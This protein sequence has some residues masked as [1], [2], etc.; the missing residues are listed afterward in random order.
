M[1]KLINRFLGVVVA[2][3][4]LMGSVMPN[5][6]VMADTNH[7]HHARDTVLSAPANGY[8]ITLTQ[9]SGYIPP[10]D[11]KF[12]AYQIFTGTVEKKIGDSAIDNPGTESTAIPLT[13]IKWGNA[14]GDVGTSTWQD[15]IVEFVLAL[16]SPPSGTEDNASAF[17]GFTQFNS[18]K[19]VDGSRL[20]DRFYKDLPKVNNSDVDFDKLATEVA[21]VISEHNDREWLQAFNDILG[22]YGENYGST[23]A[24]KY[25]IQCYDNDAKDGA[26]AGNEYKIIV[27]AGYYMVLDRSEVDNVGE[28][29][30]ARML[31]VADNIKQVIKEDAPTLDKKIIREDDKPYGTDVAGV[32]DTVKFQLNSKLPSNYDYYTLGYQYKFEDTFSKGLTLQLKDASVKDVYVTVTVKGVLNDDDTWNSGTYTISKESIKKDGA[33]THDVLYA[34]KETYEANKLTVEF[35]CLKEILITDG[36]KEYTLGC[37]PDDTN[38]RSEIYVTYNAMINQNA[39]VSSSTGATA[40]NGN[41]NTATLE[42]SDNPQSYEDTDTTAPHEAVVYIF[43][44]DITKV[45]AADFLKNDGNT[46]KSA[47]EGAKFA[48]VR[49]KATTSGTNT[50][51]EIAQFTFVGA[52]AGDPN[53]PTSFEENGYNTIVSWETIT[54]GTDPVKGESFESTWI[55]RYDSAAYNIST[56]AGGILNVSGLDVKVEY[57]IVETA[58]PTKDAEDKAANYAKIAPFTITLEPAMDTPDHPSEYTGKLSNANSNA[59]VADGKSF[60]FEYYVDITDPGKDGADP[61]DDNGSAGMIVANFKYVDLPST[62]GIGIYPFYIIGGIVVAGSII[63]FALSRRKKTA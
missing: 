10:K 43:G 52:G 11:A 18:F 58:A 49:K 59:E 21:D 55:E 32:G 35:P 56:L 5:V 9:P 23:T 57:T 17:T 19:N 38:E 33:H 54:D 2:A 16:A 34:Y 25:V 42:Y 20:A 13:D 14:F 53:L 39:V 8:T 50:E 61:K 40:M 6:A 63:L 46:T 15:N 4:L 24:T 7:S 26:W 12:G 44:L 36:G 3:A 27:P 29:F 45:D 47:L 51:W 48:V 37:N 31:F 30:S 28:A 60:S 62:G 1:K 41:K 22:G